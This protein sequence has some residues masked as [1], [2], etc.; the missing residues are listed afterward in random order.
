MYILML[1]RLNF[2]SRKHLKAWLLFCNRVL[3]HC[4][5]TFTLSTRSKYVFHLS[6]HVVLSHPMHI[7]LANIKKFHQSIRW[8]C[9]WTSV[10][11]LETKR[12]CPN[13]VQSFLPQ[14]IHRHSQ[15]LLDI[16]QNIY[17][18]MYVCAAVLCR[19]TL[20]YYDLG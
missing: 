11:L 4:I 9:I 2:Y 5:A 15:T 20:M 14:Q 8:C 12:S 19:K 17:V 6:I 3:W 16:T 7:D 1:I 10:S 18:C 13:T